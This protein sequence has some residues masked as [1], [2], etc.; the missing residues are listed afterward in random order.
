MSLLILGAGPF[1]EIVAHTARQARWIELGGFVVDAEYY[2]SGMELMGKPVYNVE[3]VREWGQPETR[4]I[5]SGTVHPQRRGMATKLAEAGF[6]SVALVHPT[7]WLHPTVGVSPGTFINA[8]AMLDYR[9]SVGAHVV[10][11]R[12]ALIGHN[13]I[14]C[15]CCTVGPGANLCGEVFVENDVV[16]GAGAVVLEGRT[17]GAGA[18]VGAGAVV[19]RDVPPGATVMG[20]PAREVET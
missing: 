4:A 11:N 15:W 14:L 12:G 18:T 20:V 19:T 16:I 7:A 1:A 13:V 17:I 8:G 2:Q 3:D 5:V 9:V 6:L 10:I